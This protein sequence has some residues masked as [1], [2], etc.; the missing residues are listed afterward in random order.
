MLNPS[1]Q[2]IDDFLNGS[3]NLHDL[4]LFDPLDPELAIP[5]SPSLVPFDTNM[6]TLSSLSS[7]IG[8]D[9]NDQESWNNFA[10]PTN[11]QSNRPRLKI[12]AQPYSGGKLRYRSEFDKN[13]SR[14]GVLKNRNEES[15]YK[16]PAILIPED[17]R[18]PN[19][20]Y[21]IRVSLVTV[22]Y[23]KTNLHYFHPYELEHPL[24]KEINDRDHNCV[25]VPIQK[26][27]CLSGTK[28]FPYL[29]IVKTRAC[30]LQTSTSLRPFDCDNQDLQNQSLVQFSCPKDIINEYN[31]NK[32]QL[33]FT[34]AKEVTI[35]GRSMMEL[36]SDTTVYSEEIADGVDIESPVDDV[37]ESTV[38]NV[39]QSTTPTTN[40]LISNCRV[41]KYAPKSGFDTSNEDMLILLTNK[42]EP[43]KY[44]RLEITFECNLP[45]HHW[46]QSIDN[47]DTK[48]R[49][50]SF[51]TPKFPY[52]FEI[53]QP[54]DVILKQTNRTL[55]TLKYYYMSTLTPCSRCQSYVVENR[56]DSVPNVP[57]KRLFSTIGIDDSVSDTFQ[58][59]HIDSTKDANKNLIDTI[60]DAV[61]SLFLNNDYTLF[62]RLCRPFIKKRPKLLHDALDNNYSDLL[63][64][65][66]PI[67]SIDILQQ[68]NELGETI[69]LHA[70]RLNQ[71]EIIQTLLQRNK[72]EELIQYI[73]DKRNNIF[74]LIASHSISLEILDL[75]I[76]YLHEKLISIKEKFDH[77][78]QDYQTPLQIAISKNNLLLT[79][80]LLQYSNT[81]IHEIKNRT[82]D[83]LIHLAVRY[84]DLAMIKYLIEDGKL[85]K[86]G[87]QSNLT[88]TPTEL[89]QSLKHDDIL[90]Y[91]NE[92]Y[93]Q[94]EIDDDSSS[95]DN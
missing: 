28:S 7:G 31:L 70:L 81:N 74:H 27:D 65:F 12:I 82:G 63:L 33:A 43:K 40:S 42:L 77:F 64:K 62:L 95:D 23:K 21:Y 57:N 68:T 16:G 67:A 69:L 1:D 39:I 92:I 49:T 51:K 60:H 22:E 10:L 58:L 4:A 34:V 46:S 47:I 78:N 61:E 83:N 3:G 5:I 90:K 41:Y 79:K 91:L 17:Y 36:Y 52:Q 20:K 19:D 25:W 44:G 32:S 94:E 87:N 11:M 13:K 56:T 84:G 59:L 71:I 66:I 88:M 53:V 26:E 8:S 73:D 6:E 76:N 50:I 14:L 15:N 80:S 45:N 72:S 75:L 38:D 29:R 18:K 35:D 86:Q 89:A 48:D 30:H 85:I 93:P 54:V 9:S 55:G 2:F 24:N 37:I